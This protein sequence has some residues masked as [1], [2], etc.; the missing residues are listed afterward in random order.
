MK[1]SKKYV[2]YTTIGILC[3]CCYIISYYKYHSY[4][5][6]TIDSTIIENSSIKENLEYLFK[7]QEFV[8]LLC[9]FVPIIIFLIGKAI[10]GV[11]KVT[12]KGIEKRVI[13][14]SIKIQKI[15]ELNNI[16][17]NINE[18]HRTISE[19]EYSRKSLDRVTGDEIIKYHI[20]NDK[21]LLRTDIENAI[22]NLKVLDEYNK[23]VEEIVNS[24]INNN[25]NNFKKIEKRILKRLIHKKEDFLIT[26]KLNVFYKS[27]GGRVYDSRKGERSFDEIKNLYLEWKNGKK[28][29]ETQR[30]E[31]KIMNDDIRYNVLKRDNFTCQICGA[32]A[33]D[34]AKLHVDHIIPISEGGKT[35]MSN[36]QT[37]CERCNIGKSNK[38]EDD[39]KTGMICPKCG[40]KLVKRRGKYGEF[41]GCSNY[42]KCHYKK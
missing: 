13:D 26:V 30:Q 23:K 29:V 31:R 15:T 18:V 25:D 3:F 41:I 19:R 22:Y 40:G 35:V 14:S 12:I 28:Y 20:E 32:T 39:F 5:L 36:L 9:F 33:K 7:S 4:S 10:I 8:W 6:E 2:I 42:P 34:G 24:D 38:T 1:K 16:F 37:L 27:N 11:I 17:K 21:N